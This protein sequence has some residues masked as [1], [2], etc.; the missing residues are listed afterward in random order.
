MNRLEC[1]VLEVKTQD[2][3]CFVKL[4]CCSQILGVLSL[5]DD[6][7]EGEKVWANFKESDVMVA[8]DSKISARNKFYSPI[9]S[10]EHN[11]ILSRITF[12]FCGYKISSLI[13]YEASLE[14]GLQEGMECFWFVKSN[15][16]LLLRNL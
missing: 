9:V 6:L 8:L 13:S 12:D 1:L 2:G 15:E 16:I 10:I 4:D 5:E 7:R 3:I 14:L 11:L